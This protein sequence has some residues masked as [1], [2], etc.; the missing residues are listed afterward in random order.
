[1]KLYVD[2][3]LCADEIPADCTF[4][5]LRDL[6]GHPEAA[7]WASWRTGVADMDLA[8]CGDDALVLEACADGGGGGGDSVHGTT[9]AARA[10]AAGRH[11]ELVRSGRKLEY[12]DKHGA[13]GA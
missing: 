13:D 2:L 10:A 7:A 11:P 8:A 1:M 9:A 6:G 3:V 4:G 5:R 12:L